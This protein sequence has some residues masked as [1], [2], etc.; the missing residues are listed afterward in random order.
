[1]E[2]EEIKENEQEPTETTGTE[3]TDEIGETTGTDT[4]SESEE[5][6]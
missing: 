5:V 4:V 1:M 6:I 3:P 2:N